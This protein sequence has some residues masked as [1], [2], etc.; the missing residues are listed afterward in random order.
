LFYRRLLRAFWTRDPVVLR[1]GEATSL[2]FGIK[3]YSDLNDILSG[4]VSSSMDALDRA[5]APLRFAHPTLQLPTG[6]SGLAC[7]WPNWTSGCVEY[8][9]H[10]DFQ[11]AIWLLF[12]ESWRAKICPKCSTY[13][14]AQKPPQL[15]CSVGCSNAV[16]RASSLNWW[17]EKG[18]AKR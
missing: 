6:L 18:S 1:T 9:S 5:L 10:L 4:E 11:R 16:H 17:R 12:S 7:F 3:D 14:L 8:I 13:F 15:Y 2:L